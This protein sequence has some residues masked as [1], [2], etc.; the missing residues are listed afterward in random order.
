MGKVL[1]AAV[2]F[3]PLGV[4]YLFLTLV[5][6]W[7]ARR[8]RSVGELF[9]FHILAHSVGDAF[10]ATAVFMLRL[11]LPLACVLPTAPFGVVLAVKLAVGVFHLTPEVP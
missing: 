7:L 6:H 10:A 8:L 4:G 11:L 2:D 5:A 3:F 1:L 9:E